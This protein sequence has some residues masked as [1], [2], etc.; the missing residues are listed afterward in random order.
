MIQITIYKKPDNQYKGFQVIGHADSVEEGADL[1]C[2]S[3]SVLT[4]N[5]VNSLDTFTDDEFEVT[6]Q[7]ELGLVQV[8]FKNPL[9]DKALLLMDSF[10]LGAHKKG[11][12]STKNGRDSE[13][14]RLGAKRADGQFVK[15]GNIL[16]RQR[17]T[18]IHPGVNV[19]RGGDDTLFAKVD[20]VLRFERKGRD[21]KQAS[22][23][24]V[25][26]NE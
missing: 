7:E 10:D 25:A 15:A 13:S 18:K 9:S 23:Y 2:C 19:G 12:G 5:L 21:K 6:E 1:V 24:P 26:T 11:V 17:G 8:T 14:K 16:Y 20:G 3:V 22:V 4:I